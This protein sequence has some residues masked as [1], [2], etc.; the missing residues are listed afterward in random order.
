MSQGKHY[1]ID[2]IITLQLLSSNHVLIYTDFILG[3]STISST[4]DPQTT[5]NFQKSAQIPLR[6][7]NPDKDIS[8]PSWCEPSTIEVT[9]KDA[10]QHA[11]MLDSLL[12]VRDDSTI[13]Q[14]LLKPHATLQILDALKDDNYMTTKATNLTTPNSIIPR[15]ANV[16]RLLNHAC[17]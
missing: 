1:G 4:T 12:I 16:R 14:S 3:C 9:T 6:N 13:Q 8:T 11:S 2:H 15:T 7:T 10:K 17:H 5:I